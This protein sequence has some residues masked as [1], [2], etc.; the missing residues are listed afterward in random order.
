VDVTVLWFISGMKQIQAS[1]AIQ[2]LTPSELQGLDEFCTGSYLL[3][4]AAVQNQLSWSPAIHHRTFPVVFSSYVAKGVIGFT[5]VMVSVGALLF[6]FGSIRFVI[7]RSRWKRLL[8]KVKASNAS[9]IDNSPVMTLIYLFIGFLSFG[10]PLQLLVTF[11]FLAPLY[12]LGIKGV[13]LLSLRRSQGRTE[14]KS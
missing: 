4:T 1:R 10:I 12:F 7:P 2:K 3:F 9:D 5:L 8:L 13:K 6:I 14:I 11:P